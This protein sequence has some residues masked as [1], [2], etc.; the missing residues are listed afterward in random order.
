MKIKSR[1]DLKI[2][3]EDAR[4]EYPQDV[5]RLELYR[6]AAGFY[7]SKRFRDLSDGSDWCPY[8]PLC[9]DFERS[10]IARILILLASGGRLICHEIKKRGLGDILEKNIVG[11]IQP[12][13]SKKE[14]KPLSVQEV[15]SKILHAQLIVPKVRYQGSFYRQY[16]MPEFALYSCELR[17]TGWKAVVSVDK[18]VAAFSNII[19]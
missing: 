8:Q 13:I 19:A 5:L 10:E 11:V 18:F 3:F 16:L 6:L 7:A 9:G 17:K 12:D 2:A 15:C 4:K 1:K 14:N